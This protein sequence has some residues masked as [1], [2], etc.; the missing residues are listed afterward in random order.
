[1]AALHTTWRRMVPADNDAAVTGSAECWVDAIG[2]ASFRFTVSRIDVPAVPVAADAVGADPGGGDRGCGEDAVRVSSRK[3]SGDAQYANEVRP[4]GSTP[5]PKTV[6]A[7][8]G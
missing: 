8:R 6:G 3:F 4:G 7:Q 1:M 2:A 5:R